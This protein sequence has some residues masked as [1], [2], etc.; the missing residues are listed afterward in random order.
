LFLDIGG[1]LL[2]DG[3]DRHARKRAAIKFKLSPAEME[4]RHHLTFETY[5]E[6]KLTMEEYL[7]RGGLLREATLHSCPVPG[8][9]VSRKRNL[10]PK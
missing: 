5:E 8:L 4:E 2:D 7:N 6:G 9:Y 10:I 1:V 3:W